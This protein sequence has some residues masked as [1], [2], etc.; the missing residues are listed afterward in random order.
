MYVFLMVARVVCF[1]LRG[2]TAT[3]FAVTYSELLLLSQPM[4]VLHFR[5]PTSSGT[6]SIILY[7]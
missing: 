2:E 7:A 1:L 6:H 4:K 3:L 5:K